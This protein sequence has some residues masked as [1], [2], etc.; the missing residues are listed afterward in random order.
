MLFFVGGLLFIIALFVFLALQSLNTGV[1]EQATA[2]VETVSVAEFAA[3][4][5]EDAYPASVTV[6]PDG[7]VYTA[8][9]VT[10]AVWAIS[11]VD[12]TVTEVNGT[13]AALGSVTG[14]AA[15]PDGTLYVVDQLNPD[16]RAAGG[17]VRR[18][19]GLP[20]APVISDFANINDA[21]GFVEPEAI[22]LD[23]DG[24]VYV[25]DRGRGE[26]WRFNPDGSNEVLWWSAPVVIA[27]TQPAPNGLA[28]DAIHD[29]LIV[30]DT[31]S[32]AV[33]RVA[34]EDGSTTTLYLHGGRAGS[35]GFD[36]VT[37]T[38]EGHIYVTLLEGRSVALLNENDD[39]QTPGT[40][41]I[42]AS[43]F[44]GPSDIEITSVPTPRFYVTNFD[45]VSLVIPGVRPQLPFAIDVIYPAA[46]P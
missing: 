45:Q 39:A 44:R 3:L 6:A 9:Y 8:S 27:E 38:P 14:L 33:Y 10:G 31:I 19:T 1:R 15:A 42:I 43:P 23:A 30:T 46:I 34:M 32:N 36:G 37:V 18:I 41:T 35:P 29:A 26:V 13:R 21:Q 5:D 25:S 22:T 17:S 40:L 4:P 12:G 16:V 28:Y 11:P 7:T 20:N 24:Y 2:R